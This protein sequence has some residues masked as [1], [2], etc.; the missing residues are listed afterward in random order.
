MKKA[1][2]QNAAISTLVLIAA[3]GLSM[4]ACASSPA[5][6]GA[7]LETADLNGAWVASDGTT[8]TFIN[9]NFDMAIN[10][11][12]A[13]KGT[14]TTSGS[15]FTISVTQVNYGHPDMAVKNLEQKWYT[16]PEL[17]AKGATSTQ[18]A[19]IY[20]TKKIKYTGDNKFKMSL[21]GATG[22]FTRS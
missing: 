21:F 17:Q 1:F 9:G 8:I 12:S 11:I 18:L 3:I 16:R 5:D 22:I 20:P 19:Q 7:S 13:I 15:S 4:A 10:K 2:K 14:Y 6:E